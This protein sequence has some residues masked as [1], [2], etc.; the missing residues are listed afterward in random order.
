MLYLWFPV[1][2]LGWIKWPLGLFQFYDSV[3]LK[4]LQSYDPLKRV[5]NDV[6]IEDYI[7]RNRSRT[8]MFCLGQEADLSNAS[9]FEFLAVEM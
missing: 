8:L 4:I 1:L 5:M 9:S 7:S 3:R 6:A 2:A